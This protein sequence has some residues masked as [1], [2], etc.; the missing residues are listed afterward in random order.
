MS[1][2]NF[3][4]K[5]TLYVLLIL[6][7]VIL[8]SFFIVRLIGD[9]IKAAFGQKGPTPEQRKILEEELGLDKSLSEQLKYI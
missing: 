2:I 5:K 9:P 8:T 7:T 3:I 6:I 1:L 4:Y